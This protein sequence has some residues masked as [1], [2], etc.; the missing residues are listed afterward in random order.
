MQRIKGWEQAYVRFTIS[1]L[2]RSW[3]W[4]QFDCCMFAADGIK[5][6]TGEDFG[7]PYRGQYETESEAYEFLASLGYADL[8]ALAS[9]RLPEILQD[10][11]PA[12]SLA[13][14]CDIVLTPTRDGRGQALA[15]CDGISLIG[16]YARGLQHLPMSMALRAWRVG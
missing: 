1:C 16:P 10:G 7:A 6:V 13:R 11:E 15:I 14:R 2:R 3:E 4:S 8:G 5:A 9:S 12:P